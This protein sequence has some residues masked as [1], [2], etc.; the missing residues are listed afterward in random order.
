MIESDLGR[1]RAQP[2][3]GF[4]DWALALYLV[5]GMAF[6]VALLG[7]SLLYVTRRGGRSM[8]PPVGRAR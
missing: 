7:A 2:D 8:V 6:V 5:Y 4:G 1:A 3:A